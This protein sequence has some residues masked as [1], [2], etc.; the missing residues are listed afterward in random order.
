MYFLKRFG[1]FTIII[2]SIFVA[3]TLISTG[4]FRNIEPKFEGEILKK[5]PIK[6][7]EDIMVSYQDSF[8]LISATDRANRSENIQKEGGLFLIDLTS[9]EYSPIPLTRTLNFPFEPHGISF[10]KQDS[11]YHVMAVNHTAKGHT[12]E[13]F[14]LVKNTLEHK[15]TLSDESMI[16]PNDL[17]MINPTSFYFTNDHGYTEGLGKIMEEYLGLA[18]SNVIYC[19]GKTYKE[20]ANGIAYA[21]G[22]NFDPDR[23]LMFVASA[24][25]FVLKVYS[26]LEDGSLSFIED[27]SCGTG[28]DNIEFDEEKNLWIGCHPNLL[29]FT[30]YSKGKNDIAPSE[31]IK[32]SYHSKGDYQIQQIYLENGEEMSG[33]SAAAVY[34]DLILVGN[35]MDEAFLILKKH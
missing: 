34:N 19:D 18:I 6:G 8:A 15:R 35:V 26:R 13:V 1:L 31:V 3:H 23:K 27:I 25:G 32:I 21:N 17:V 30:A 14:E 16:Q 9:E 4:Y 28:V 2:I 5:V 7:A 20:V 10:Y 33:S 24:R 11:I 29:K 12:I 22:I